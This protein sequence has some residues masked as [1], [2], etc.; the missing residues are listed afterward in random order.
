MRLVVGLGNPGEA[1]RRTRHNV[2]FMVVDAL[3]AQPGLRGSEGDEVWTAE[4]GT[5]TAAL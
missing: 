3:A 2:G 1:Y 4:A 5:T